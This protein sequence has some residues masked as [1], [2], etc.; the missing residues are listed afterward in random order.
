MQQSMTLQRKAIILVVSLVV[1]LLG[2]IYLG[3]TSQKQ[4]LEAANYKRV[5][6]L[7]MSASKIVNTFEDLAQNGTLPEDEAKALALEVLR[8]NIYT[9]TEYVWVTDENRVFISA[10]LDPEIQGENF[11]ILRDANNNDVG[12][13]L[14]RAIGNKTDTMVDY[15]WS[16]R[17][18]D[19]EALIH[20]VAIKL[21]FGAGMS[22]MVLPMIIFSMS[23][24]SKSLFV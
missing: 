5:E 22:A 13:I 12:E 23:L 3:A 18:G 8:T 6:Q 17:N 9:P 2:S 10:P 1:L 19:R 20:S 24:L 11:N 21:V 7:L 15:V 16:S 4:A 14:A